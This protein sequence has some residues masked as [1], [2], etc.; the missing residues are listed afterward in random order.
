MALLHCP[1]KQLLLLFAAATVVA[2][3]LLRER[4]AV[5]VSALAKLMLLYV[6]C[7]RLLVRSVVNVQLESLS[8]GFACR[9]HS[10]SLPRQLGKGM[11]CRRQQ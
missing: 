1:T 6:R 10:C 3:V 11:T 5:E 4:P 2:W 9:Y 7:A 8:W